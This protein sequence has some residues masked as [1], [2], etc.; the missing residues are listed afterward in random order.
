MLC[1]NV[2][3]DCII[4]N[5]FYW[6]MLVQECKKKKTQ[7]RWRYYRIFLY[8][9]LPKSLRL[10][11]LLPITLRDRCFL[12][13]LIRISSHRSLASRHSTTSSIETLAC[14][15]YIYSYIHSY[16]DWLL[17]GLFRCCLIFWLISCLVIQL[18]FNIHSTWSCHTAK[19][20]YLNC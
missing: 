4:T 19:F 1:I 5:R 13:T 7:K 20:I 15:L 11:C 2:H 6:A 12:R 14:E 18:Y 16:V 10:F 17:F 3:T 8:V 9:V